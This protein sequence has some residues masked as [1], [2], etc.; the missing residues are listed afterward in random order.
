MGIKGKK[1]RIGK[2]YPFHQPIRKQH[3]YI[4]W[5]YKKN[6]MDILVSVFI[7]KDMKIGTV[8]SYVLL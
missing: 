8:R 5:N 6:T 1:L 4:R 3:S 7:Y 2:K